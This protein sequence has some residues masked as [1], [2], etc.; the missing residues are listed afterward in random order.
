[1]LLIKNGHVIDPKSHLSAK[2]DILIEND[3]IKAISEN[4]EVKENCEIIDAEGMYVTPGLIDVHVHFRDPGFTYKEDIFTG[5]EAAKAGGFTTVVMMANTNPAIDNIETLDYVL[6]RANKTDIKVLSC[7]D[8][9]KGLKGKELV[10][11]AALKERGAVGFTDDGIPLMDAELLRGAMKEAL[12]LDVPLSFHEE[13]LKYNVNNGINHGKASE[14]FNIGGAD[15]QAEIS[16]MD[17][18]LKMAIEEGARCDFQHVSAKESI[19]LIY[20]SKAKLLK[21]KGIDILR[22]DFTKD[23]D[24]S[25]V[26]QISLEDAFSVNI[27][28]EATP[29][30]FTLT[31]DDVIKHGAL[32]KINPPI[33]EEADRLAIIRGL[34]ANAIDLI[35][36]DHAPHSK[37]EKSKPI[38]EAPSG[39][40]GLETSLALAVTSLVKPGYLSYEEVIP[41][42]TINPAKLYHLDAGYLDENG[43]ADITIFKEEEWTPSEYKS[44]SDNTPFTGRTLSAKVKYTICDGKIV[45]K[46]N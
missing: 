43:P 30:H 40:I 19:N 41:K 35:V 17:R 11:M 7:G 8:I 32:A 1:M 9:T 24:I 18:D 4:I 46:D 45:Y 14:H 29:N 10:D 13:D 33:R 34:K 25:A 2:R 36:T 37:E 42:M 22:F 23:T 39:I 3:K 5:A 16:M 27:H 26:P 21:S 12:K 15:R 38:T 31:E 20:E 44:K 28:A 6:E